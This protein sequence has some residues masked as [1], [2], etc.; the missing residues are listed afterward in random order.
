MIAYRP[1]LDRERVI[2]ILLRV[3]PV[4]P[5]IVSGEIMFRLSYDI[6]AW[7]WINFPSKE[8]PANEK[9]YVIL[10]PLKTALLGRPG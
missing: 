1:V 2:K 8:F 3:S 4:D 5:R 7:I 10:E 6:S 9:I